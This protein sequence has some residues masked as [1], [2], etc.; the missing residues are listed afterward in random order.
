MQIPS[1]MWA[2]VLFKIRGDLDEHNPCLEIY[3]VTK[4]AKLNQYE[5]LKEDPAY[6]DTIWDVASDL[7]NINLKYNSDLHSVFFKNWKMLDYSVKSRIFKNVD[8]AEGEVFDKQLKTYHI[9]HMIDYPTIAELYRF[10]KEIS[11]EKL[12]KAIINV[13]EQTNFFILQNLPGN[14]INYWENNISAKEADKLLDLIE[15]SGLKKQE[16]SDLAKVGFLN[17]V[18]QARFDRI[19]EEES[20]LS[21]LENEDQQVYLLKT[22]INQTELLKYDNKIGSNLL[23]LGMEYISL[24]IKNVVKIEKI[25]NGNGYNP[26]MFIAYDKPSYELAL[27]YR[28]AVND[29]IENNSEI[30]ITRIK[31]CQKQNKTI[32]EIDDDTKELADKIRLNAKLT[33]KYEDKN[34]KK[35]KTQKI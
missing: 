26:L 17:N 4:V 30:I 11:Q 24:L 14:K 15:L 22:K 5:Y 25:Q 6:S 12:K 29:W 10:R 19:N 9:E 33:T 18:R 2:A 34:S 7:K 20:T 23:K 28:N 21:L 3:A 16:L 35:L 32:I 27:Q 8:M 31:N 13:Y 1:T